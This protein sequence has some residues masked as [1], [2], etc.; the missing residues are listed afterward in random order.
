MDQYRRCLPLAV[1]ADV[2]GSPAQLANP[3]SAVVLPSA[4]EGFVKLEG[5]LLVLR[6][7]DRYLESCVVPVEG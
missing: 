7:C 3:V 4:A 2:C 1:K 6:V 5:V